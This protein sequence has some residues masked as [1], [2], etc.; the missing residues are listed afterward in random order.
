MSKADDCLSLEAHQSGVLDSVAWNDERYFCI[1][2]DGTRK[3]YPSAACQALLVSS[4]VFCLDYNSRQKKET[5]LNQ[6]DLIC[7]PNVPNGTNRFILIFI[8]LDYWDTRMGGEGVNKLLN[9]STYLCP[10]SWAMCRAV[11]KPIS[12]FTLPAT[13]LQIVL[14]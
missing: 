5:W 4:W 8:E 6:T 13:P 12:W 9:L 14:R 10:V 7:R 1:H 3:I 11:C 2:R